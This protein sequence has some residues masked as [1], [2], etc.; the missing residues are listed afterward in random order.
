[1]SVINIQLRTSTV[2]SH[3]QTNEWDT[4]ATIQRKARWIGYHKHQL[5]H[6]SSYFVPPR[7]A[8]MNHKKLRRLKVNTARYL[9]KLIEQICSHPFAAQELHELL[10]N[11]ERFLAGA[12]QPCSVK[13][14]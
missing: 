2:Y 4:P 11:D 12:C 5:Q 7:Q 14:Q 8:M 9:L 6:F 13:L 10:V 1:M 3:K